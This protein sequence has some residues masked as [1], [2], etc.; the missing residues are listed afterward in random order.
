MLYLELARPTM[1]SSILPIAFLSRK[2]IR[3]T[4]TPSLGALR[5]TW[6]GAQ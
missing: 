4:S 6:F 2:G 1:Q 5:A 3:W